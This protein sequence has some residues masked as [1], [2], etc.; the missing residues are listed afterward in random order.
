MFEQG[1]CGFRSD[2]GYREKL[3]AEIL[4]MLD[5]MMKP[6]SKAVRFV[7]DTLKKEKGR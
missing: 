4:V 7:P 1:L 6:S 5:A 2:S 3:G